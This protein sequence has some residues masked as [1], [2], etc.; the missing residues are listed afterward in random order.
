MC[1]FED[2][3]VQR[4]YLFTNAKSNSRCNHTCIP[5]NYIHHRVNLQP[6][7][8]S[9][10][11]AKNYRVNKNFKYLGKQTISPSHGNSLK[12]SVTKLRPGSLNPNTKGVE[13]KHNSYNRYLKKKQGNVLLKEYKCKCND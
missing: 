2:C 3:I 4:Q 11:V 7:K 10:T 13:I 12:S 9:I 5:S 8:A 6:N 1:D